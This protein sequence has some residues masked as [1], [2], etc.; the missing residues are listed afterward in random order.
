LR[1]DDMRMKIKIGLDVKFTGEE[2]EQ[3]IEEF[4]GDEE[5][6]ILHVQDNLVTTLEKELLVKTEDITQLEVNIV[7][8]TRYF[9]VYKGEQ[10]ETTFP[11]MCDDET[12]N[13]IVGELYADYELK[14]V[15]G[16]EYIEIHKT[17]L[18]DMFE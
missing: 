6:I 8:G 17:L 13:K 5:K 16:K 15:S 10:V 18:K 1:G 11:S 12:I 2:L 14:E 7:D 9:V 3:I 4:N